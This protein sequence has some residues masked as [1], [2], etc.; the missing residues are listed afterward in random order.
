LHRSIQSFQN[1]LLADVYGPAFMGAGVF[2]VDV[3]AL[4][5][6]AHQHPAA[7]ATGQSRQG[8]FEIALFCAQEFPAQASEAL[9]VTGLVV[10]GLMSARPCLALE[11]KLAVIKGVGQHLV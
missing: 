8:E 10:I 9:F 1:L 6:L 4:F 5:L 7:G 2:V 11:C 3:F